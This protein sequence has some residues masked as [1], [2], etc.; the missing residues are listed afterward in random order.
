MFGLFGYRS[1]AG[2]DASERDLYLEALYKSAES[3]KWA[4]IDGTGGIL[5]KGDEIATVEFKQLSEV[6]YGD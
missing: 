1:F 4:C 2:S 6:Q 5:A 3:E